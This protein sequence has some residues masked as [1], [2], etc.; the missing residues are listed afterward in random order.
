MSPTS[1]RSEQ[2]AGGMLASPSRSMLS[3]RLDTPLHA[4][5]AG[6][7]VTNAGS[8]AASAMVTP[9]SMGR[10]SAGDSMTSSRTMTA[11]GDAAS[12][13]GA[14]LSQQAQRKAVAP[15]AQGGGSGDTRRQPLRRMQAQQ[16]KQLQPPAA[17]AKEEFPRT[18]FG[19]HSG[20][21]AMQA[22]QPLP[23]PPVEHEKVCSLDPTVTR[24]AVVR[25]CKITLLTSRFP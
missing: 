4:G 3:S 9:R 8:A 1:L 20:D 18:T 24:P 21:A 14:T 19:P 7:P 17:D 10:G 6:T 13:Q 12:G 11:A 16:Q 25:P 23:P 15:G 2:T 5:D 22:K